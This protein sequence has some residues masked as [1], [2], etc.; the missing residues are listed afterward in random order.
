[1]KNFKEYLGLSTIRVGGLDSVHP[2]AS[3]GDRPPKDQGSRDSRATGLQANNQS[4]GF[5]TIKPMLTANKEYDLKDK[6]LYMKL[7]RQAMSVMPGSEKQKQIKKEI[8]R[9][10]KRLGIR[11]E[12]LNEKIGYVV[13]YTDSKNKKFATAFKMKKDA[14]NKSSQLKRSGM[15]DISITTHNINYNNQINFKGLDKPLSLESL[16]GTNKIKESS[17][18]KHMVDK[19]IIKD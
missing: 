9:V 15:K 11:E 12:T 2:I 14:E 16:E 4:Q 8:E 1:M 19:K 18:Y 3:L 17:L 13:R 6:A 7:V 5:G 10:Q